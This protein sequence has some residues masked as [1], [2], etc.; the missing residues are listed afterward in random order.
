MPRIM[1]FHEG[2][3]L[4]AARIDDSVAD[5][6]ALDD[7]DLVERTFRMPSTS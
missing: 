7:R 4:V 1:C 6:T 3:Q 2:H 5:A